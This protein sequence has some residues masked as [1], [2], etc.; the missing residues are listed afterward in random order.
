M[1][2]GECFAMGRFGDIVGALRTNCYVTTRSVVH[3]GNSHVRGL[4]GF[5]RGERTYNNCFESGRN[6]TTGC[7]STACTK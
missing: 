7:L 6:P 1:T 4:V 2:E 3:S 5:D